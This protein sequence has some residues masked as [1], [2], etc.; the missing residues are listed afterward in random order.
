MTENIGLNETERFVYHL[1]KKSFL[2]L[3]SYPNPK[4]KKGNELCDILVVCEP[5][6][7]IFSVKEIAFKDTG[8]K[9]GWERWR[10]AAIEESCSQIAG[11]ERWIETNPN[12]I[13]K[14]AAFGLPFP[15]DRVVHRVAVA[16]GSQGNVPMTFG[17]FGKG[18]VHVFDEKS[19]NT[20][21]EEL[22]TISDFV[23]YL[24][25]KESF[26]RAGKLTLFDG[27]GEEDLLALYL[28]CDRQFPEEPDFIVL[29]D[30]LWDHFKSNPAV[31]SR[32]KQNEISYYWDEIIEELYQTYLDS[33]LITDLPYTSD[34]LPDLEKAFRVMARENRFSRRLLSISLVDFLQNSQERRSKA[35]VSDSPLLDARYVFLISDYDSNRK[36]NMGE[37]LGR[38]IVARGLNQTKTKVIGLGVEFSKHV[39]GSATTV[40]YLEVVDWTDEWQQQMDYQQREFGYF[41]R[42]Q[43]KGLSEQEFPERAVT[44]G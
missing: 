24:G 38:C 23:K 16:L 10:R 1:C 14:D 22:D 43:V 5:D 20:L 18:F 42:P 12:V 21:M 30:D 34:K 2:S 13:T 27:G 32:K 6:I 31:L 26:Y 40:C 19:L 15:A 39:K 37:L 33:N 17:D 11:A 35:R 44:R 9:V 25:D 4:G 28:V 3:W 29:D 7:I 36:A 41:T 8:D